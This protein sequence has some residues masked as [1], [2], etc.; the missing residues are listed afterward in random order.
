MHNV[1]HPLTS[2][3]YTLA[4]LRMRN[5]TGNMNMNQKMNVNT[6]PNV[7]IKLNLNVNTTQM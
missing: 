3:L 6:N 1:T 7:N 2:N 5:V 4:L